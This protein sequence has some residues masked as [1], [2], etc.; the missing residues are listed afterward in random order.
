MIAYQDSDKYIDP[1]L[2][3]QH[4]DGALLPNKSRKALTRRWIIAAVVVLV[5]IIVAATVGA[6]MGS[7]RGSSRYF[8]IRINQYHTLYE[9]DNV[10][11]TTL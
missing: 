8:I 6:V 2:D 1:V 11:D 9:G 5:L 4:Q 3:S 7:K 10:A